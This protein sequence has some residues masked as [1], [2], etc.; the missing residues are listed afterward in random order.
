MRI[1]TLLIA[2][3]IATLAAPGLRADEAPA[4]IEQFNAR[5]DRARATLDEVQKTLEQPELSDAALRSLRARIEPL[6]HELEETIEKLT[7]RLAAIDARLK[8]LAPAAAKPQE[9]PKEAPKAL[10]KPAEFKPQAKPAV[11]NGAANPPPARGPPVPAP[12]A[13]PNGPESADAAARVSADAELQEQRRLYDAVDATLKRARAMLLE[14]RQVAVTIVARQRGLFAKNLFLRT[15]GLFSPSLWR[16]ALDG[17]P[18]VISDSATFLSDRT[19]NVV[20]RVNNGRRAQF[21][22]I[23]FLIA[24]SVALALFMAR[25]V[26]RR[27]EDESAP[28]PLRKAAAA[29]WTALV[30][31]A[32][33]V[34][35]VGALSLAFDAYDLIDAALEPIWRRFVEG[36]A[37]IA[38]AYAIARAVLAPAHPNWR[39]IDPGDRLA[40]RLTQLVTLAAVTLSA[41]R[42]LEQLEESVQ[43]GFLS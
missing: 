17:A 1:L 36:V 21:L 7:P 39:L 20:D 26:V 13:T 40:K 6:P 8:E 33:P 5:L 35:A 19:A 15:D 32:A 38:F 27:S 9:P 11:K 37:R 24:A 22:A 29:G 25:R 43:G 4:S 10:E 31:V 34:A 3:L 16:A 2:I 23:I 41:A 14:T 18:A 28:T 30:I 12:E 42:F